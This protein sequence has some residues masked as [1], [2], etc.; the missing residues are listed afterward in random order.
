MDQE[1]EKWLKGA[2]KLSE[3]LCD[4]YKINFAK[5]LKKLGIELLYGTGN[6][7]V[8]VGYKQ[9]NILIREGSELYKVMC[10]IDLQTWN[11][12]NNT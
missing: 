4:N 1:L 8:S 5:R 12:A 9:R 11:K 6:L 7:P 10:N 3:L 2:I